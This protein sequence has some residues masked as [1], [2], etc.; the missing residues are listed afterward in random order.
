MPLGVVCADL[1][2]LFNP[3]EEIGS[4]GS[5]ELISGVADHLDVVLTREPSGPVE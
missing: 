2:V 5:R 3:D 1:T 4:V